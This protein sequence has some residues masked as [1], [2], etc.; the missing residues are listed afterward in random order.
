MALQFDSKA[1]HLIPVENQTKNRRAFAV[2]LPVANAAQQ[3]VAAVGRTS[4]LP[5]AS[6]LE[7]VVDYLGLGHRWLLPQAFTDAAAAERPYV[8]RASMSA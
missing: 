4:W 7:P 2:A 8:G 1:T 6:Y 3:A 5:A